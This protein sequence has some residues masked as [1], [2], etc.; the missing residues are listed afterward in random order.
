MALSILIA[1]FQNI[2]LRERK[3]ITCLAFSRLISFCKQILHI[4]GKDD[5]L[6]LTAALEHQINRGNF[7]DSLFCRY[8]ICFLK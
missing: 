7:L 1:L 8:R 2:S 4:E 6:T 5:E 3:E